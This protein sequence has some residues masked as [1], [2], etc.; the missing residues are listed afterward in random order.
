[1]KLVQQTTEEIV[2]ITMTIR[3]VHPELSKY[4]S[5]MDITLPDVANPVITQKVLQDYYNS[6]NAILKSYRPK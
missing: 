5:E 6:L 1:M 2:A 4:L 3:D